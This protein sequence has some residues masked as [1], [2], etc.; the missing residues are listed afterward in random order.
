MRNTLTRDEASRLLGGLPYE[1]DERKPPDNR[2][3]GQFRAGWNRKACSPKSLR[4]LTWHN[5]GYRVGRELGSRDRAEMDQAFEQFAHLYTESS[6]TKSTGGSAWTDAELEASVETYLEMLEIE[7]RGDPVDKTAFYRKLRKGPLAARTKAAV[8]Q[9]MKSISAVLVEMGRRR[10]KGYTP[11]QNVGKGV[12]ERLRAILEKLGHLSAHASGDRTA[13]IA[14]NMFGEALYQRRARAAL[15]I[16]VRQAMA[17]QKIYYGDLAEELGMPNPRNLNY[18]LG[19]IGT[20][21]VELAER[22]PDEVP[23]IQYLVVNQQ[24]GLPGQGIDAM[25]TG[26]TNMIVDARQ[27][28]A[29]VNAALGKI[30]AYPKWPAVLEELGLQAVQHPGPQTVQRAGRRGGG[31]ESDA[32]KRLKHYVAQNPAS[33]GLSRS[34]APGQTEYILPSGDLVDVR[35]EERRVGKEC[36]S[37]WSPYH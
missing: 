22:W 35:S 9:R 28:E 14:K 11:R 16:L 25:L 1:V 5:L 17:R 27:K 33:V 13:E 26:D 21:L 20:T 29:I 7:T 31:G 2:R 19:S 3:Q 32:H 12:K 34:L 24:T 4:K 36:R 30:F 8:E 23:P 15:P 6:S 37:R 18:V 10:I